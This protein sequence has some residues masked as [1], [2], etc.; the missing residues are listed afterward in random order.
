MALKNKST[1][2]TRTQDT[3]TQVNTAIPRD[4][5]F[6]LIALALLQ[7]RLRNTHQ[8]IDKWRKHVE[9]RMPGA[10]TALALLRAR[11]QSTRQAI[12]TWQKRVEDRM[13]GAFALA[14]DTALVTDLIRRH[15]RRCARRASGKPA[16]WPA[17]LLMPMSHEQAIQQGWQ[18]A[19][20]ER[21]IY[22]G[23]FEG[24]YEA[25]LQKTVGPLRLSLTLPYRVNLTYGRPHGPRRVIQRGA[26]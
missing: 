18:L 12:E 9:D 11:I 2:P 25:R 10:S 3:I 13:P 8:A 22:E 16:L 26:R 14:S 20:R 4:V 24:R 7:G 15:N 23:D 17:D 5:Q 19:G 1:I 21:T 6:G